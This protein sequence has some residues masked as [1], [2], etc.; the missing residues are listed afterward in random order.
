MHGRERMESR[1][2]HMHT[3]LNEKQLYSKEQKWTHTNINT[4]EKKK[5]KCNVSFA[6]TDL[7]LRFSC[8]K[9]L[10][11]WMCSKH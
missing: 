8:E 9:C 4:Y 3:N 10:I 5:G 11:N 1:I 2:V 7:K 6:H